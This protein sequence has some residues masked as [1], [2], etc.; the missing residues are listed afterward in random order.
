VAPER[1][2]LVLSLAVATVVIAIGVAGITLAL[3]DGTARTGGP[4]A[5]GEPGWTQLP[6]PPLSAR[7]GATAIT[8]GQLVIVVGGDDSAPC[9]P[10]ADCAAP[11]HPLADGAAWDAATRTW[12]SIAPA[13]VP[14]GPAQ[15]TV[16]GEAAYFWVPSAAAGAPTFLAYHPAADT[17]DVL[18]LPPVLPKASVRL[19]ATP[20]SIV[21]YPPTH[22]LGDRLDQAFDIVA[23]TWSPLPG[24]PITPAFDRTIVAV[25]ERLVVIGVELVPNPGQRPP[26]YR[27]AV[28]DP[29][30]GTWRR[31]A[32]A[33]IVGGESTWFV[34][35]NKVVN[36]T[37]GG[38]DGG[39]TNNWGR[40]FPYGGM[41]D[42]EGE[43]WVVLPQPADGGSFGSSSAA[44]AEY[45]VNRQG[46][47][48]NVEDLAWTPVG[49]P[50]GGPESGGASAW[51]GDRLVLF[52]GVRFGGNQGAAGALLGSA[53]E[54]LPPER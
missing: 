18:P 47:A 29:E 49:E 44:G 4:A 15:V 2:R 22:E 26:V 9:P 28:L 41:L 5:G 11:A 17:W 14:I 42:L 20:G 54:W 37:L 7:Q 31:L 21:A 13:P 51:A 36:P 48:L 23:K 3:G 34:A 27:A 53:W 12:R 38:A 52:G 10:N 1:R 45:V 50:G 6:D 32:D 25:G 30:T 24:D 35:G 46:W 43:A 19:V 16:A 39:Q 8:V 33:P 40:V